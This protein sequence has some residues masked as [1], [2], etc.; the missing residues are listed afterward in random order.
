[1]T[2]A[3][4]GTWVVRGGQAVTPRPRVIPGIP[5]GPDGRSRVGGATY[6]GAP[7]AIDLLVRPRVDVTEHRSM[8]MPWAFRRVAW[9]ALATLGVGLG[10]PLGAWAAVGAPTGVGVAW[11]GMVFPAWYALM[12]FDAKRVPKIEAR[13]DRWRGIA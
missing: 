5:Y 2:V 6:G 1:M 8:V 3:T 4:A 7:I 13:Y 11:M 10:S 9:P 12:W